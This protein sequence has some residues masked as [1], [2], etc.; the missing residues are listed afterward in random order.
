MTKS[1]EK[2]RRSIL[3]NSH[4]GLSK[5]G[6]ENLYISLPINDLTLSK[7]SRLNASSI[8]NI[9]GKVLTH[10]KENVKF[11]PNFNQKLCDSIQ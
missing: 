6:K 4:L 8:K 5:N 2:S 9:D 10:E 3:R 1:H 7:T 11:R